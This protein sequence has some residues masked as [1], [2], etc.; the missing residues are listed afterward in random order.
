M[1]GAFV[2]GLIFGS[3]LNVCIIRIP[4]GGSIVRPASRCPG[5]EQPIR[6]YDNIP[7]L[8]WI[9]LR[10]HCR[11]CGMAI[12]MQYPA[13]ELATGLWFATAI[14]ISFQ[15]ITSILSLLS[16]IALLQSLSLCALGFLLIG[17]AVMDWQT[18]LL[19]DEFT[20]GGIF[21][22]LVLIAT[23]SFFISSVEYKT[24]FTPEEI[25]IGEHILAAL[26]AYLLLVIIRFLYKRL[27]KRDGMG[28]G[29]AKLLALIAIFLGFWPAIVALFVAVLT[30]SIY[31]IVL[32][33]RG[34]AS[35]TSRLPFGS[36]LAVAGLLTSLVG[37]RI[38]GWYTMLFR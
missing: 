37:D 36:F 3:F 33:L 10:T 13:V 30:A 28:L 23:Q 19:P 35:T 15:G 29:D 38:I 22:G 9:V 1:L 20:L 32:L 4:Q 14:G 17:L 12:S 16:P 21:L 34:R 5:C 24:F 11:H 7:V 2:I 8:S 6:W 26:G 25:L 27:R 31:G 18:Q